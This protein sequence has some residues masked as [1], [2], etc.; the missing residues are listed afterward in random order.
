MRKYTKYPLLLL[1]L[2]TLF[3]CSKPKI[4]A[5]SDETMRDSMQAIAKSLPEEEKEEFGK[6]L[7][8]VMLFTG[9]SSLGKGK[10]EM[11]KVIKEKLH[12]KTAEDIMEMAKK[13]QEDV[14]AKQGQ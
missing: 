9:M 4:D 10:E 6:A 12:G 7:Q 8:A 14:K 1:L 2:L 13:I 3:A 11:Q 5:T